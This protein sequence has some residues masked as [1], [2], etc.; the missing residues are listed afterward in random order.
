VGLKG[1]FSGTGTHLFFFISKTSHKLFRTQ[2]FPS[3]EEFTAQTR[4]RAR[5]R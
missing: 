2:A 3:Q 4:L 5:A 1:E